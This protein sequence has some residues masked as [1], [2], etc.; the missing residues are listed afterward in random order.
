MNWKRFVLALL[1][2]AAF[3]L[4]TRAAGTELLNCVAAMI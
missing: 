1:A 4:P 3:V 2:A